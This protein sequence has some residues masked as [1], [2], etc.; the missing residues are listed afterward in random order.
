MNPPASPPSIPVCSLGSCPKLVSASTET[1]SHNIGFPTGTSTRDFDLIVPAD[2]DGSRPWPLVFAFHWLNASAGSFV[3]AGELESATEQMH[4][5]AVVP[6]HKTDSSGKKVYQFDWPFVETWG[7]P[8]ELL[9]FDDM[10][11]CVS[12]EYKVD[13]RRVYSVGVSAGALWVTYLS[14]TDKVDH[15]AAVESLSVG[16]GQVGPW[17][18]QY[19]AQPNKFPAIVL[20]GGP[21]DWL[22]VDFAAASQKYRDALRQDDHFVVECTHD[23]GHAMPPIPVPT[24]GGTRFVMLWQFMLDHP[25]GLPPGTSPY[26]EAGLPS[27]FPSWCQIAP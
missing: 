7:V 18:M 6:N 1:T 25:Y 3:S 26:Q 27:S 5:I 4:F 14:T 23:A 13:A 12:Q 9:F 16:L 15:L 22:V 10:L 21:S 8:D 24:D 2:Y 11:A 20:W 17:T 19:A